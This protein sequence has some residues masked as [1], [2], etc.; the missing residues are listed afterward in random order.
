M[1]MMRWWLVAA[2][3]M[4]CGDK[5]GSGSEDTADGGGSGAADGGDGGSGS[6]DGSD[7]GSGDT[8]SASGGDGG[9]TGGDDP[10]PVFVEATYECS[11]GTTSPD[12]ILFIAQVDD[13][14]GADTLD[15]LAGTMVCSNSSG[16]AVVPDLPL[17]CGPDGACAASF[18]DG[19]YPGIT[20][21]TAPD[22]ACVGTVF[23]EDG[24]QATATFVWISR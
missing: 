3:L 2:V 12:A 19:D 13:P 24:N 20:C 16:G 1:R 10:S 17:A 7:G 23:D 8:G 9:A 4:G 5:D 22:H 18:I 11:V 15:R 6:G 21:A 14:Q